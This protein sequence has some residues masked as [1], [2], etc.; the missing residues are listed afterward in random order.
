[1]TGA[2]R[3]GDSAM[4]SHSLEQWTHDHVYL[5]DKHD[6]HERRTWFVV[7]LT[8]V[9]MVGEIVAGTMFGSMALLADGWHMATHAAA[10]GIAALAYLLAR[11]QAANPHFTFGTGKFGD[12]AASASAI[13]LAI[14]AIQICFE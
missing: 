8:A 9:M 12:L 14:V 2:L 11:R 7:A 1:M 6:R 5:G 4:H 3:P 10:L 13:I